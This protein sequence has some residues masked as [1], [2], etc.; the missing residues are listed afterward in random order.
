MTEWQWRVIIALCR[1]VIS[2]CEKNP[3]MRVAAADV[4]IVKEAIERGSPNSLSRQGD[5]S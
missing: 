2:L 1:L 4:F 3:N 5:G